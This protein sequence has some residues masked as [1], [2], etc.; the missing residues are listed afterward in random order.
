MRWHRIV[1]LL[2]MAL[3]L[4]AAL[5]DLVH[6]IGLEQA[7]RRVELVADE[8]TFQF[9]AQASGVSTVSFPKQLRAVGVQGLG[10]PED[11][12]SSLA[13]QGRLTL[14][15]GSAWLDARRSAGLPPPALSVD[16]AGTYALLDPTPQGQALASFVAQ[17][18]GN[19][20]PGAVTTATVDGGPVVGIRLSPVTAAGLPLGF[21]PGAFALAR[22][23]GMDVV[24]RPTAWPQSMPSAAVRAMLTEMARA[25]TRT[26]LFAGASTWDLPGYPKSLPTLAAAF[27]S[28][29]WNLGVLE[30]SRLLGNVNQP[31][32]YQLYTL[33]GERAIRVYS[34]PWWLLQQYD[35]PHAVTSIAD[36][37]RTRNLRLVYLHPLTTGPD[38]IQRTVQLYGAVVSMLRAHGFEVARPQPIGFLRVHT[39]QR[40]VQIVAVIAAWLLLLEYLWPPLRRWGYQPLAVLGVLGALLAVGSHTLS[41]ELTA[42]GAATAFGGLSVYFVADIWNR[43]QWPARPSLGLA[44]VRAVG[45]SVAAGLITFCGAVLVG[46]VLGDTQ[47]LL[48]WQ[49]FR[50][51]KL[52]YLGIPF[53]ALLAFAATVGLGSREDRPEGAFGEL[54]WLSRQAVRYGH[55]AAFLVLGAIGGIY[56][57]R[58]GNVSA[59]AVPGIEAHMRLFLQQ[60][61]AVR[62]REKDFLVGYPALFVSLVAVRWRWRW[63]FLVLLLGVAVGQVSIVDT[64]EHLHSP[65]LYS[66]VREGLGLGVGLVT[67]TLALL[68]VWV[69]A[70][71]WAMRRGPSRG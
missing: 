25:N 65:F 8:T 45:V 50:G 61:L 71:V 29:G 64:F 44:W 11:T 53:L 20:Y 19:L 14:L 46:S 57:L 62:P 67:G 59:S 4:L 60:H 40:V 38:Q 17:A 34:V 35:Q 41:A 69:A 66:V 58:S 42:L 24:A 68:V 47:H 15:S 3:G 48:E 56:L 54:G 28:H 9:E 18:L 13:G 2:L 23:A 31:G 70:W 33:L 21:A 10:V 55:V 6:R 43:W 12:L 16:P 51:V 5:P 52:T 30:T 1:L 7:N 49:Y 32:T 39:S 37:V 36:S 22:Q 26:V 63:L 27:Q